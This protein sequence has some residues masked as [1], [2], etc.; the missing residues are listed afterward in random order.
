MSVLLRGVPLYFKIMVNLY[1]VEMILK[2]NACAV[3]YTVYTQ[4]KQESTYAAIFFSLKRIC[5][6][7]E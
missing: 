3:L 7:F 6:S 5:D 2:T 1:Y 4:Q